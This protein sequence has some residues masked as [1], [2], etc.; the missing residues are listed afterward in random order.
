MKID[1]HPFP[2]NMVNFG[3]SAHLINHY[4]RKRDREER[5]RRQQELDFDPHWECAF[6]QYCWERGLK[7]PSIHSCPACRGYDRNLYRDRSESSSMGA[8]NLP[9][10]DRP[11]RSVHDRLR[12]VNGRDQAFDEE[13]DEAFP[14]EAD[15]VQEDM[16]DEQADQ[17]EDEKRTRPVQ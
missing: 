17:V 12:L 7:L 13:V 8:S 1:G 2:T 14:E 11:R 16:E 5:N 15:W 4:Q 10:F 9:R 6:F 3:G